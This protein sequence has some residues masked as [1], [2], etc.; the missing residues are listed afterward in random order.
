MAE[1]VALGDAEG[2]GIGD[3]VATGVGVGVTLGIL[4]AVGLGDGVAVGEGDGAGVATGV[5][6]GAGVG[7]PLSRMITRMFEEPNSQRNCA[8]GSCRPMQ[9]WLVGVNPNTPTGCQ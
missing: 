8:S 2:N 4:V 7:P 1:G 6:A 9:P 3:V 5:G